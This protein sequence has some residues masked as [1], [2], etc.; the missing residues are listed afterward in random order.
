MSRRRADAEPPPPLYALVVPGLE[1]VA[2][3]EIAQELGGEV[4][5][6]A[7]GLVVFRVPE[8]TDAVRRL[9]TT[10]DVFLLA[11]GTDKLTRRAE[12]LDKIRRW[13]AHEADWHKLLRIHHAVR[14][15]PAGKPTYHLVTQMQGHHAYRRVDAGKELARGLAG[16]FPASWR[17]AEEHAAVE[18]WLTID[19]AAAVCG[20]R[21]SDRAMRHRTYKL[22]H[23]PAS[24]RPTVAAAM[25][26]LAGAGPGQVVLDPMC[27]AGTILAEQLAA[28]RH[29]GIRLRVIGGD[30]ERNAVKTA[31]INLRRLGDAWL[32]RWDAA[33]LP[34]PDAA[35]DRVITNPPFGKQLATPAQVGP[36]YRRVL[37]ECDRVLRPG[38]QAAVLVSDF[39][40]LRAAARRVGW[41]PGR[42]LEL[43]V[44]GQR[45][46][47]SVW[48]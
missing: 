39:G 37:R 24:L 33:R 36:L 46:V 3:E 48:R 14:P 12:D 32:A 35:V 21:L 23:L 6:T 42:R 4:K 2:A 31:A 28:A 16:K 7:P 25:V 15:K 45:A 13:T 29:A 18:V 41:Q 30:L 1:A 11:W 44:L 47:L 8:I 22:E 43:R 17:P 34:L 40:A 9:R 26:R 10:E 20:L 19:G 27:G 5:K 38:G